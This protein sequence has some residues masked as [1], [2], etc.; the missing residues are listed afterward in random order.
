MNEQ[1]TLYVVN[2]NG[3][4]IDTIPAHDKYVKLSEGDKVFRKK[5]LHYLRD[6][7]DIKY[8]FVKINFLVFYKY[9][10]KYSMLATL[11]CHVGYMDNICE[12]KNG[13]RVT[14]KGLPKLCGVSPATVKRQ[15]KGMIAD[16]LIHRVKENNKNVFMVNPY[17]C[18]RGRRIYYSTYKEFEQSELKEKCEK[19]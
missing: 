1:D 4:V 16:D 9:C 7:I 8:R 2:E 6:T 3:E 18:M 5:T 17:L 15:L 11:V 13:K 10:K 14:S 12:Y 19:F